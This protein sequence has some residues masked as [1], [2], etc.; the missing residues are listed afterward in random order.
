[1]ITAGMFGAMALFGSTTK[2]SLA[3][4]G[5]FLFMGLIGLVLASIVGIFWRSEALQFLI[6]VVG[7][8]VFTGLTAYDAQRLK[9]MA[10]AVPE[11]Q[12]GSYAIMGA[13]K[14][15]LDFINLFLMLLRIFGDRRR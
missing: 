2:R 13:L 14:L 5:Q 7:V 1:M 3:G 12:I 10:L 8:I 11:G 4:F 9:A 15:Y 6:S